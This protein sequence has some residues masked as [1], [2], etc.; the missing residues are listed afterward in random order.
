MR[1]SFGRNNFVF[2]RA[3]TY[4]NEY[5][6]EVATA[7]GVSIKTISLV[8]VTMLAALVSIFVLGPIGSVSIYFPI[9]IADIILLLIMT[10]VP[11][12]T[13]VL[14]IPYAV[15]EGLMIGTLAGLLELALP[16]LGLSLATIAFVATL[17]IFLGACALYLSGAIRVTNKLRKF[18]FTAVIGLLISSFIITIASIF[19]PAIYFVFYEF[20]PLAILIS[21]I[22]IVIAA[23][24][25]VISLDN[26][27][28][29]V[30]NGLGKEYEW[31]AAFGI[32]INIIWLFYEVLRFV[33]LIAA[34]NRD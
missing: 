25:T 6:L 11:S 14:S 34:N 17:A 27:Y 3:E 4:S 9:I 22:Y 19:N 24:Y 33:I 8:F 18:V 31:Y 13:K 1:G 7:K 23:I 12:T 20:G 28:M 26:A 2:Q 10:F 15:L 32:L 29:V 16:D 21:L 30:N 5:S